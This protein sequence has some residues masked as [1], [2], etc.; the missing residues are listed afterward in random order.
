M[1]TI[2]EALENQRAVEQEFVEL[3]RSNET[4]PVGWPAA[5]VMFHV[6]MWRERMRNSFTDLAAG[7]ETAV[8]PMDVD[9]FNAAE[10]A[11][12]IGTPLADAAGRADHLL[13]ELIELYR[14]VGERPFVWNTAK[15]TT[16]A[17]LRSSYIHPRNHMYTY[18]RENGEDERAVALLEQAFN[19]MRDASAPPIIVQAAQ[20]NLACA[21]AIRG[22][23]DEAVQ[24]LAEV[25]PARPDM[26]Q[27]APAEPDLAS[28]RDD[29]R[30]RELVSS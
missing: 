9:A 14:S 25:L 21:R 7:R 12:G 26:R 18:L 2:V 19:E 4:A 5:L 6:G 1:G 29:A 22:R 17:V 8:P 24:L 15:N 3:A 23:T 16:E 28:L 10:L 27:A 13:G 11:D 30:F 20:Y